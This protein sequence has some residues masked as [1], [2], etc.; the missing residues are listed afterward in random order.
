MGADLCSE[1]PNDLQGKPGGFGIVLR[2]K[3]GVAGCVGTRLNFAYRP[4]ARFLPGCHRLALW[5]FTFPAT[6]T[7][8]LKKR[9][10]V[11]QVLSGMPQACP[12]E[13]HVPCYTHGAPQKE[14]S[15]RPSSFRDATGLPCGASRSLLHPQCPSKKRVS[16]GPAPQGTSHRQSTC[17]HFTCMLT[18]TE[19][20]RHGS[21]C[22]GSGGPA[23]SRR[24]PPTGSTQPGNSSSRPG[25][26]GSRPKLAP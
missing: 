11:G 7:V 21:P 22:R 5:S 4:A 10:P 19:P 24:V 6:P 16:V 3:A 2:T 23:R 26:S 15:G 25:S 9:A 1:E 12:V 17:T 20:G 18:P 13:P 14:S 8:P